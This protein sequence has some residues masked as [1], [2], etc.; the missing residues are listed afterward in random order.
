VIGLH[1]AGAPAPRISSIITVVADALTR[2]LVKLTLAEMGTP[3]APLTWLALGS[4][5]RSEA[6]LSSDMDSGLIWDGD[7]EAPRAYMQ[8]LGTRVVEELARSGFAADPHGATA[9]EPLFDRSFQAWRGTLRTLIDDPD[10]EKAL[11]YISLVSDARPVMSVGDARDPLEEL[12]QVWHRRPLLRLML[13][14]ALTHTPPSGLRRRRPSAR[15]LVAGRADEHRGKIDIKEGGVLPVVAI[16]RYGSLA[17]G[18]RAVST[19]TRLEA[20]VTAGTLDRRDAR[21]LGEAFEL[22]SRLRMEHQVEQL[23]AGADPDNLIDAETLNPV[24]RGYLREAFHAV[25]SVQRSLRGE[26][27]LLP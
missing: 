7:P 15:D 16:A 5:G 20:A 14:L 9:A 18:V 22:F 4:F 6:A 24:T 8:D 2:R 26:L 23:R 17:A 25:S 27:A 21:M 3:P 10:R 13:R 1:D 19:R 11:I 12:R